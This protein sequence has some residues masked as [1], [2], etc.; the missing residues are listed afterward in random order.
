MKEESS[1]RDKDRTEQ[2]LEPRASELKNGKYSLQLYVAGMTPRSSRAIVNIK[3]ICEDR[4]KDRYELEI[5]D[6]YQQPALAKKEQIIAA[7]TLIKSLPAPLRRF[8]GDMSD[9]DRL[10]A[11]L[12]LA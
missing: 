5:V 1:T 8:I 7:P 4:L 12:G 6:V 3:E 2:Q 9:T 10:L 11:G